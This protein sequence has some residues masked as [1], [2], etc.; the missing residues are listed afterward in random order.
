MLQML[1]LGVQEVLRSTTK[2]T[3]VDTAALGESLKANLNARLGEWG[4]TV[5][6][7]GFPTL[8][9]SPRSLRIT[10]LMQQIDE[11]QKQFEGFRDLGHGSPRALAMVGTRRFPQ[12]IRKQRIKMEFARS[13]VR[14]RRKLILKRL[15]VGKKKKKKKKKD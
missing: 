15:K 8:S 6:K 2:Q 9:P 1:T 4:V 14:R 11:R 13:L 7:A 10:Q 5:D 12:T 3:I